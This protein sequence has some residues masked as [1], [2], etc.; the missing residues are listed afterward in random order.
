M[1]DYATLSLPSWIT[2][3]KRW[4]KPALANIQ[5]PGVVHL[6]GISI[7]LRVEHNK[8]SGSDG[9][10]SLLRG[11]EM[12]KFTFEMTLSS[13]EDEDAWNKITPILLPRKDPTQRGTFSVYHPSLARLQIVACIV[14]ELEEV[15]PVAGGPLMAKIHC[16]AVLPVKKNATKKVKAKVLPTPSISIGGTGNAGPQRFPG[17]TPPSQNAP[18][19]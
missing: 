18:V 10:G 5:L 1:A 7:K 3:H 9:G 12:P 16:I 11:L 2:D 17:V 8:A 4:E 15:P 14:E 13:K 19:K 6:K